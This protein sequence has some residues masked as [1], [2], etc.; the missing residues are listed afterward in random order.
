MEE[1]FRSSRIPTPPRNPF[2]PPLMQI[3][4]GGNSFALTDY[5]REEF[6]K[7]T[8]FL[9]SKKCEIGQFLSQKGRFS[10][11]LL[12]TLRQVIGYVK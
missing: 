8:T 7:F 5:Y 3:L 9:T 11:L 2:A 6:K 10:C 1:Y 4:S 12:V